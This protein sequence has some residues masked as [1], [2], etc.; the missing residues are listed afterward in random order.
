[1]LVLLAL[2]IGVQNP[3]LGAVLGFGLGLLGDLPVR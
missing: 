3:T 1:M 2:M